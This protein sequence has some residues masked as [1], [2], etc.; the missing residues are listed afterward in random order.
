MKKSLKPGKV[1]VH[2]VQP[3]ITDEHGTTRFKE[4]AIVSFLL[5]R[6]RETKIADMNLLAT[7]PFTQEDREQ[8][9]QL[10]GYSLSGFGELSYVSDATYERAAKQ[11]VFGKQKPKDRRVAGYKGPD[12]K[13]T[14]DDTAAEKVKNPR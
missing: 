1:A 9:A 5:D 2:P 12:F 7:I 4:N 13:S 11:P 6:A 3:L 14:Y 8:F 10:V